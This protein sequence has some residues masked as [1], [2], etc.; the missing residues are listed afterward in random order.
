MSIRNWIRPPRHLLAMF[1]GTTL[2]SA[3]A[4]GWLSWEIVRQDRALAVQR[5]Q[6]QRD[7]AASLA[8]AALEKHLAELEERLAAFTLL[9]ADEVTSDVAEYAR[10][11]TEDSVLLIL[12][13]DQ[14]EAHPAGH[15]LYF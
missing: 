11:L 10:G 15:L 14:L 3:A 2:I 5:A 4:L 9:P 7:S 6:E 12:K 13:S 1:I 8:V